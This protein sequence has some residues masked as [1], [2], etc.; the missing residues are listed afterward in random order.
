MEERIPSAAEVLEDIEEPD[1]SNLITED[2][3]PVDNI[4]SAKQQRLLV[5][6]LY[7]SYQPNCDF[8]A[9]T[10]VGIFRATFVPPVVPDAFLSLRV[11]PLGDW[12]KKENRSY[13][14]WRYGKPPEIAIEVVS[15]REGGELDRKLNIYAEFRVP[16]Y[17]VFDP[18]H[19]LSDIVLQ[20]FILTG[21]DYLPMAQARF[22]SLNL[23]LE[24]R[25][26]EFEGCREFWLRWTD[27]NGNLLLTGQERAQSES[28]RAE[29]ESKRAEA[30][31]KRAEAESKRAEAYR[32]KLSELGVDPDSI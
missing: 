16:Y 23:A 9:D 30:E 15:N 8:L 20:C 28:K 19:Q 7:S 24:V 22:D 27:L 3:E 11:K 32:Q 13:F 31:S 4:A 12:W 10:N 5:D 21:E 2:D 26:G 1:V 17:V 18:S 25:E 14:I 29:A 6:A